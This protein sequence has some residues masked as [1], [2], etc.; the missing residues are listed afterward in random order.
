[1]RQLPDSTAMECF[2][3]LVFAKNISLVT[4][5]QLTHVSV[6]LNLAHHFP[7]ALKITL[8][9]LGILAPTVQK[10]IFW[11]NLE[12]VVVS[13]TVFYRDLHVSLFFITF[14]SFT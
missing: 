3:H 10:V 6:H 1:M 8:S 14:L 12:S 7:S 11:M 4:C 2:V 13:K 5:V 9:Q